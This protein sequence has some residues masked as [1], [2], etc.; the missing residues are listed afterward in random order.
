MQNFAII[1][2]CV[3][4]LQHAIC[5][6]TSCASQRRAEILMLT[7]SP[8]QTWAVCVCEWVAHETRIRA[9]RRRNKGTK[10]QQPLI[11][12]VRDDDGSDDDAINEER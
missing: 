3:P 8:Q 9:P 4:I 7:S 2:A 1:D 11:G 10:S 6:C 12:T 5:T